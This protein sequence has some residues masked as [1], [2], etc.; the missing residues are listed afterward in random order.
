MSHNPAPHLSPVNP[1]YARGEDDLE[2]GELLGANFL[3]AV[4]AAVFATTAYV[5]VQVG[6]AGA[7]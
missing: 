3:Y 6:Q 1:S 5:V 7:I 2:K 4:V